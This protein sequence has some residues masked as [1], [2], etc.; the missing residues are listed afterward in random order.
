MIVSRI[1][2][3]W[4]EAGTLRAEMGEYKVAH[5][6]L[7]QKTI[8]LRRLQYCFEGESAYYYWDRLCQLPNQTSQVVM[9][10]ELLNSVLIPPQNIFSPGALLLMGGER[11]EGVNDFLKMAGEQFRKDF[12]EYCRWVILVPW[13]QRRSEPVPGFEIT[14]AIGGRQ[15][16]GASFVKHTSA[17]IKSSLRMD[18]TIFINPYFGQGEFSY[19]VDPRWIP[20]LSY[21]LGRMM[22]PDLVKEGEALAQDLT[23]DIIEC[24]ALSYQQ[25]IRGAVIKNIMK[26]EIPAL[27]HLTDLRAQE[28]ETKREINRLNSLFE[29]TEADTLQNL[30]VYYRKFRGFSI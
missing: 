25:R 24:F 10:K 23:S 21:L 14:M 27:E 16:I 9:N 3:R 7:K 22:I 11:P 2:P 19:G 8:P 15:E 29:S 13:L 30:L 20:S 6:F 18:K 5:P 1:I 17:D 26:A 4:L 12:A 28:K